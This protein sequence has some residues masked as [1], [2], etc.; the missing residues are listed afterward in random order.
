VN[1]N[2]AMQLDPDVHKFGKVS[3]MS[4][5]KKTYQNWGKVQAKLVMKRPEERYYPLNFHGT[6]ETSYKRT[7]DQLVAGAKRA[8]AAALKE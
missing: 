7:N 6:V 2:K 3:N 1:D 8:R 4:M 5:S